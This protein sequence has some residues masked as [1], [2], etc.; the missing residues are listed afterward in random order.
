MIRK[1]KKKNKSNSKANSKANSKVAN[2][3]VD[4]EEKEGQSSKSL[5]CFEELIQICDN[6]LSYL[7]NHQISW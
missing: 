4:D 6:K 2:H 1:R 3:A 5:D 7:N